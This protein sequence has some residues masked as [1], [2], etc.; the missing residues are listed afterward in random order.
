MQYITTLFLSVLRKQQNS[1]GIQGIQIQKQSELFNCQIL[2]SL[3][4]KL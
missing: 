3:V 1:G 4:L 2:K